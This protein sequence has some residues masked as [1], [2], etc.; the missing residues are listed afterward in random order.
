MAWQLCKPRCDFCSFESFFF[1]SLPTPQSCLAGT[2]D[3]S[4][5]TMTDKHPPGPIG[6]RNSDEDSSLI[7][8]ADHET[9]LARSHA[10]W[11]HVGSDQQSKTIKSGIAC[12]VVLLRHIL[13]HFR[14]NARLRFLVG[15][16]RVKEIPLIKAALFLKPE[17]CAAYCRQI[18]EGHSPEELTFERLMTSKQMEDMVWSNEYFRFFNHTLRRTSEQS[19][20][21]KLE[22]PAPLSDKDY[23]RW[24]TNYR[25]KLSDHLNFWSNIIVDTVTGEQTVRFGNAPMI[26]RL[27]LSAAKDGVEFHR[28]VFEVEL[29]VMHA[30]PDLPVRYTYRCIAVVKLRETP[31]GHDTMRLYR[32]DGEPMRTSQAFPWSNEW[33]LHDGGEYM[34]F[35]VRTDMLPVDA[36]PLPQAPKPMTRSA[37]NVSLAR[38][39]A[40]AL[41]MSN[42]T[43]QE[44]ERVR[45]PLSRTPGQ[46]FGGSVDPFT[47]ARERA[48][49]QPSPPN[50][51]IATASNTSSESPKTHSSCGGNT[52]MADPPPSAPLQPSESSSSQQQQGQ[53]QEPRPSVSPTLGL[54]PDR[55]AVLHG[56]PPPSSEERPSRC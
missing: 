7:N 55:L 45:E 34:L 29:G 39:Y 21:F 27:R 10:S 53:I 35:Y 3:N 51:S 18:E 46:S 30:S 44:R 16:D 41:L 12:A 20:W 11:P 33:C 15:S 42:E 28:D 56:Y 2:V 37:E 19:R 1:H 13:S 5:D 54:Y 48:V 31:D 50:G 23:L 43:Y 22:V 6:L 49:Q 38:N 26:L 17:V 40:M 14:L 32:V 9:A 4:S 52:S 36:L 8:I 25:V 24:S 47:R